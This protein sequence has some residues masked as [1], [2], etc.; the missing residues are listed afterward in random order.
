MAAFAGLTDVVS[1]LWNYGIAPVAAFGFTA[2]GEDERFAERDTSAVVE[3]GRAYGEINLESLA[4]ARPDVIVTHAYPTDSAGTLDTQKPLYG[5]KDL[6]Q[7]EAVAK[8]APIVTIAMKGSAVD[9]IKRTA[10]LAT[11]LGAATDAGRADYETAAKRLGAASASAL[12]VLVV[13]AYPDEGLYVA[14]A[15]DDPQLRS[16]ADLGVSFVDP[17][18]EDYYWGRVS[19]EN[20]GKLA[21]DVVLYSRRAMDV[22]DMRKQATFARTP[23][24]AAGQVYPWV[25]A[26]MDYVSQ[27]AYMNELAANLEK[28]RKVT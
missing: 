27:A 3:V 22:A 20:A 2:I 19:W 8:I 5:F 12:K 13:A 11:S 28:S 24:A 25:F 7:Q 9:V 14:K 10:D 23:A 26:G 17:G 21:A 4:A 6:A 1:S 15:P 18:G 16:Y